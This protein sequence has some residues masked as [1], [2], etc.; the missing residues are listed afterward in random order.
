MSN[1]IRLTKILLKNGFGNAFG[2]GQKSNKKKL[3]QALL[4]LF[5]FI[6]ILPL[7]FMVMGMT[8]TIYDALSMIRQEGLVLVLGFWI[9]AMAIFFFGI[10]YVINVFYFSGD[11]ENLLPLPLRP[12]QIL[13]AKFT[14]TLIYE[15]ITE[16]FI[17][18]PVLISFGIKSSGGIPYIIYA[19]IVFITLPIVPIV[20]A[21]ILNMIIMRF[22]NIGKRRDLFRMIGGIIGMVIAI[23]FN[24]II[25]RFVNNNMSPEQLQKMLVEGNNSLVSISNSI[26][27]SNGF[28][29]IA[30]T[31][32]GEVRALVNFGFYAAFTIVL[33]VIFLTLGELLYFKGVIGVSETSSKRRRLSSK[34]YEKN[35]IQTPIIKSY[36]IKEIKLLFRTPIYFMNCILMNFLWPIFFVIPLAANPS[37]F[38][39]FQEIFAVLSN[40]KYAGIILVVSFGISIF[41]SAT[42]SIAATSISREGQNIY[43]NK[44]IPLSYKDQIM[45]KVLSGVIVSL[46]GTISMF[47]IA[48][49]VAKMPVYLILLSITASIMAVLFTSFIGIFIDLRAPKLDWDNEQ[50]AVKQNFNSVISM[51]ACIFIAALTIVPLVVFKLSVMP[52]FAII[53]S[54]YLLINF[55]LYKL[56]MN[57][58]VKLFA[59]IEA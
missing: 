45:A 30:L 22:T 39:A 32:P 6:S 48:G 16:L 4:Y 11:I 5:V 28:A 33:I 59:R 52:V 34:E 18:L 14:V 41:V 25:Q 27:P 35:V 24:V 12:S 36:I 40:D 43:F 3:G 15:Y 57:V 17:L 20:Y 56:L 38:G 29:A 47:L 21:A 7:F 44:Y 19:I 26:F 9:T 50:K 58:G 51:M 31:S 53:I 49:I 1:Y 37:G 10:F 8:N 13:G 54:A 55:M 23:G 2:K 42:N 46:V